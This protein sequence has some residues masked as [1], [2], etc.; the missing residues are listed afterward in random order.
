[1]SSKN[2]NTREKILTA[3]WKLLE[4][5]G[6]K[7]RMSDIA[8]EAG[9]SRQA[10]Y[11]HFPNR[12]ELLVATT[13]FIDDVKDVDA[14]LAKSRAATGKARLDAFIEAW[15]NYIPEIYGAGKALM[16]LYDTD[17]EA[18]TAWDERMAAVRHGCEAAIR[19]LSDAG[20]LSPTLTS[21]KAV[22]ALWTLLSVRNWEQLTQ[23]CGWAQT[24]YLAHLKQVAHAMLI[25]E[26]G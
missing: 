6:L 25:K 7:T 20:H 14:R 16:A 13:R 3:C 11:L 2:L 19:A 4:H 15:G 21:S 9:V 26:Q 8:K 1:M 24:D 17:H 22:D 5:D 12:A 10:V 18:A 23:T